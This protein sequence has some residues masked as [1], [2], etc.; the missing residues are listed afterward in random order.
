MSFIINQNF[1]LK[2][3]QFNFARDYYDSIAILKNASIND[4][5]DHFITNVA[6]VLY[7]L[8]KS[9]DN[10]PTTGK[11]RKIKLATTAKDDTGYI[12]SI[13]VS[14]N[15][16]NKNVSVQYIQN[17]ETKHAP[18]PVV[19]TIANGAMSPDML[20][21]L[22]NA[23]DKLVG[24][25]QSLPFDSIENLNNETIQST[26]LKSTIAK[27]VFCTFNDAFVAVDS[28]NKYYVS[29]NSDGKYKS[30]SYYN[31]NN[32]AKTG[33]Y[34]DDKFLYSVD[35]STGNINTFVDAK[36]Y[37]SIINNVQ[38]NRNSTTLSLRLK[39]ISETGDLVNKDVTVPVASSSNSGIMTAADYNACKS[40]IKSLEIVDSKTQIDINGTY[41]NGND[42]K[43]ITL[44]S[45]SSTKAG[46]LSADDKTKLDNI[47]LS[48]LSNED[49]DALWNGAT[50]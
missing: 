47:N 15:S 19:S 31:S 1:D 38:F 17:G 18:I 21:K 35:S 5:P 37:N 33:I 3:P 30:S 24:I 20:S 6:G 34:N 26:T 45:A 43:F 12:N 49:I 2:S 16:S 13:T 23:T 8:D 41:I 36:T 46:L 4:F 28:G 50:A 44:P 10:D 39:T 48:A 22:N 11:W 42:D 14:Q 27:I 32:K 9:L 7:Q 25:L 40:G 29:W